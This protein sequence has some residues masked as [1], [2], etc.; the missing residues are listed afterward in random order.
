MRSARGILGSEMKY[1]MTRSTGIKDNKAIPVT[2]RR[3]TDFGNI[4]GGLRSY[5]TT[6]RIKPPITI[7]KQRYNRISLIINTLLS[8]LP[9]DHADTYNDYHKNDDR[10]PQDRIGI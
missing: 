4:I 3:I 6:C 9:K 10:D 8:L 7:E 1:K 5:G 2:E